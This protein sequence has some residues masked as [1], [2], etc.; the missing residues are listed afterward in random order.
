MSLTA[1]RA[2]RFCDFVVAAELAKN[3]DVH[4]E[5]WRLTFFFKKNWEKV[6]ISRFSSRKKRGLK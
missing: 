3:V 2:R 6:G 1:K 5:T 4:P